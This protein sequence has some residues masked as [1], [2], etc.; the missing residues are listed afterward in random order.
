MRFNKLWL[1]EFV[2]NNLTANELAD[3]ITMAGLEVDTVEDVCG[4]FT[5]VVVG[6]VLTCIDHPDSDH[7]HVT[8]VNVGNEVLDIV[9]GAPNCRA[10]LKVACAIVGAVLPGDFKIKPCKLRGVPSNG[11]LC[12]Y[13]ELGMKEESDGIIEL[14]NDAPIGVDLHE[15]LK[16]N[17]KIIDVD[18][19]ANRAD[20]L[21]IYGLA[22]EVSVLLETEVN[23]VEFE[24]ADETIDDVMPFSIEDTAVTQRYIS[25]VLKG[26]D[27][28]IPS[29]IWMQERLRRAGIR[30]IDVVVD[31]TNY[32]MLEY[33]VPMHAYDLAKINGELVIRAAKDG[34]K[35]VL[36]SGAEV[37]LK[38]DTL[39]IA[40]NDGP[41]ALAGIFG[42]QRTGV[43][44]TTT[45][46][47]LE[48]AYFAPSAIKNRA[49]EYG[50]ATDA[51]HRF[52]R[53]VDFCMVENSMQR[54]TSLLAQI[55]GC[56]VGPMVEVCE[57]RYMATVPPIFV[58]YDEIDSVIGVT[59][60]HDYV[61]AVLERLG[62]SPER[63]VEEIE[64]DDLPE[65]PDEWPD[66]PDDCDDMDDAWC[67]EIEGVEVRSPSWRY[68]IKIPADICEEVARIYGYD[69]IPNVD[70]VAPLRMVK[71]PENGNSTYR[72]KCLMADRGYHEVVTYSFVE[73]KA[74][75]TIKPDVEP[76][77]I[78]SP[79]SA[80]M[81]VMRTTLW[82]GLINTAVY[83][84][85]RQMANLKLFETGLT[86]IPDNKAENGI[87]QQEMIGGI[88]CGNVSDP[89]WNESNRAV[90]F[91]DLKGDVEALLETTGQIAEFTFVRS[92]NQSLH[93]GVSADIIY[94][95]EVVGSLGLIH[96]SVE[97]K[98]GLKHHVFLFEIKMS[99]LAT[100]VIPA[101]NE[102]SKFPSISRDLAVVVDKN[103][104]CEDLLKTVKKY[105][106]QYLVQASVFDLYEGENLPVGKKS[107]AFSMVLQA[108][109][110]T[111]EEVDITSSVDA[112][113][114]GLKT[115]FG[116][117]LRE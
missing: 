37:T 25:R 79:I 26:V 4:K 16:L 39:V 51:S 96:P 82:T 115:D 18:L 11:M 29:P 108:T 38:S 113:V 66:D 40:D 28:S 74:L 7:L 15:Y 71:T 53:G 59:I 52:E 92:Q 95:N 20:C 100:R 22:R 70:P 93:P 67:E 114:N 1:D 61:D 116:A 57:E 85:N 101:Y 54:A 34:E 91:F 32:V 56:Q 107:I 105:G 77:V 68:D 23:D 14:P 98:L 103:V 31:V 47:V 50:L 13:K 35:L 5:G 109:E 2:S 117:T 63:V 36:L 94:H 46:I 30:S 33:G 60:D 97:K 12:S 102:I 24:C 9:C 42:G 111:L 69:N 65:D 84:A 106:G 48:A 76:L 10:G 86:F 8:T 87:R 81:S 55:C 19:T 80:D 112:V 90:D 17:D 62:L 64:H 44:K 104:S 45:D 99:A 73:P 27:L 41:V 49:R 43:S 58:K 110:K 75:A 3:K 6:E 88:L 72:L 89:A 21:S 78:P 83:N